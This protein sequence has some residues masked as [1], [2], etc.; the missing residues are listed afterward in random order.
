MSVE[1]Q[2]K[3]TRVY[4]PRVLTT[5]FAS[6][7][8]DFYI[9]Y[10]RAHDTYELTALQTCE[11]SYREDILAAVAWFMD[12]YVLEDL[13]LTSLPRDDEGDE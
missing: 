11:F 1:A 7:G 9:V 10:D 2:L 5:K 4:P 13:T 3:K 12:N 6:K 8:A